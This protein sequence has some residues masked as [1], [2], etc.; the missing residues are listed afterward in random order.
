MTSF[1]EYRWRTRRVRQKSSMQQPSESSCDIVPSSTMEDYYEDEDDDDENFDDSLP[2][3]YFISRELRDGS[4]Q[5]RTV[6]TRSRVDNT[7]AFT[8]TGSYAFS[9]EE[10]DNEESSIAM[11]NCNSDTWHQD[12]VESET[13]YALMKKWRLRLGV[14]VFLMI[15]LSIMYAMLMVKGKSQDEL[16]LYCTMNR[17]TLVSCPSGSLDVPPCA[18]EAFQELAR[19]LLKSVHLQSYPCDNNHFALAAVAV[20]KVNLSRDNPIEDIYQYWT[21]AIIYFALGGQGWISDKNW[22][23]GNSACQGDWFGLSCSRDGSNLMHIDSLEMISNNVVGSFPSEITHLTSLTLLSLFHGS[24]TG[25]LPSEIGNMKNL[26]EL[27]IE[28]ISISGTIPSEIGQCQ[29]LKSLTLHDI[30]VSGTIPTEIGSL[31]SLGKLF[32]KMS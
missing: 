22:L 29:G 4:F 32:E 8:I 13:F 28:S 26:S 27:R 18:E 24:I 3:A 14:A 21:L 1:S 6:A 17:R 31:T 12:F 11:G 25:T 10:N 16:E 2:G 7:D 30:D 23:T 20:V 15:I 9:F 5:R 19:N